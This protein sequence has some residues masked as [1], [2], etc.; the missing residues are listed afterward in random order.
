MALLCACT[1][2]PGDPDDENGGDNNGGNNNGGN[3][4]GGTPSAVFTKKATI[5]TSSTANGTATWFN[6]RIHVACPNGEWWQ[7]DIATNT[8]TDHPT[9][10]VVYSASIF[11]SGGNLYAA[12]SP[13]GGFSRIYKY[14]AN[15]WDEIYNTTANQITLN[16]HLFSIAGKSYFASSSYNLPYA[17]DTAANQLAEAGKGGSVN[18]F[19]AYWNFAAMSGV[20]NGRGYVLV[21]QNPAIFEYNPVNDLWLKKIETSTGYGYPVCMI[22]GK[23][24]FVDNKQI[25][26]YDIA[27]NDWGGGWEYSENYPPGYNKFPPA[28]EVNGKGYIIGGSDFGTYE[29]TLK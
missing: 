17:F 6:N 4:N 8:W 3:N 26:I 9:L 19:N 28:I 12:G 20:Y 25:R 2:A 13:Q 24:V 5:G 22:G 18:P 27:S 10:P 21:G 14:G 16:K 29:I 11:S 15:K 1:V 23:I 7:Y